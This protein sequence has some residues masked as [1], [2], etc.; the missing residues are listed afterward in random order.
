MHQLYRTQEIQLQTKPARAG[1]KYP[2]TNSAI[3]QT[4]LSLYLKPRE[5][6]KTLE[7]KTIVYIL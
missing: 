3:S 5:T 1:N 4:T 6:G 2:H 7:L